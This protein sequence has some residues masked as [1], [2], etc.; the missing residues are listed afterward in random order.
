MTS[1]LKILSLIP[2]FAI[3]LGV[4]SVNAQ[5]KQSS[6]ST[7]DIAREQSQAVVVI[8]S[9][10]ESGSVV[11]QGS[12]FLVTSNGAIVSNLH[13]IKGASSLRVRLP[14]G[15]VYKT[16]DVIDVDDSKDI[17]IIKIKGFNLPVV[18]LGDSDQTE[19]GEAIVAISSPEGL[20]NSIST[21][22]ISG[23]RRLETH[24]VFQIT[25]P[26]SQGSSGGALFNSSG[27]V[28]G[29]VTY[30]FKSGQNIN[31]AVPVNYVRGMVSDQVTTSLEQIQSRVKSLAARKPD[32][33]PAPKTYERPVLEE[34]IES[35]IQ[36]AA[37]G[38]LGLNPQEPMFLRPDQALAFF[39]RLVE[40]I[41]LY[42][43]VE[44]ND[45]AR[46]AA[47][48]KGPENDQAEILTIKYLDFYSGLSM[49]FKKPEGQLSAVEL[50]VNWSVDDL[51]NT[52]GDKYKKRA[53]GKQNIID[54][55]KLP[56]GKY[57]TA[58]IDSNGN[59]RSVKFTK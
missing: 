47:L 6:K 50:L 10:N 38:K 17:I 39:Y 16:V 13:V 9:L 41:G 49:S 18:K 20:T 51:R 24:R 59:V 29:I 25:A 14:N 15:D 58:I 11:E 57:L 5:D 22:V 27:E 42:S 43:M 35:Q 33:A 28:I 37:R 2:A 12:G 48:L 34:P 19:I 56:T 45:L 30:L 23:V 44:V 31:F 4:A 36:P 46:T 1:P 8:E 3:C 26:I 40:G 52:F 54:Y 55:G 32:G 53:S 7:S 21:G